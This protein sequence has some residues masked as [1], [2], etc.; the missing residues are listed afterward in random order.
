MIGFLSDMIFCPE[1]CPER[2]PHLICP[3]GLVA[4]LLR[5]CIGVWIVFIQGY[6]AR[7]AAFKTMLDILFIVSRNGQDNILHQPLSQRLGTLFTS[8]MEGY[9]VQSQGWRVTPHP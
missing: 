8:V 9:H 3:V 2:V 5:R 6:F 7:N 1:Y 4:S